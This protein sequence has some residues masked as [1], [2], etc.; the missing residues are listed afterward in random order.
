MDAGFKA[1]AG[2]PIH[3]GFIVK[4]HDMVYRDGGCPLAT[5]PCPVR[6]DFEAARLAGRPVAEAAPWPVFGLFD[7][8]MCDWIAVEVVNL[9]GEFLLSENVKVV[10]P[11]LPELGPVAFEKLQCLPHEDTHGN[12][13]RVEL[14]LAEEKMHMLVH[15]NVAEEKETVSTAKL[16]QRF[17]KED[18]SYELEVVASMSS[19]C[20]ALHLDLVISI[21]R[22]NLPLCNMQ[23]RYLPS[24]SFLGKPNDLGGTRAQRIILIKTTTHSLERAQ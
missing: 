20:C 10:V 5:G 7:E 14:W 12:G 18:T 6:F 22:S 11:S 2:C 23:R 4:F 3:R 9:L 15:E 21:P 13:V 19:I 8:A 24:E 1:I 16:F 17:L